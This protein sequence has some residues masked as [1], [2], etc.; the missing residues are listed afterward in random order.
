MPEDVAQKAE[1]LSD[2]IDAITAKRSA[3]DPEVVA[4]G[5]AFVSL[6]SEGEVQIVRG[7]VRAEDEPQPEPEAID[8]NQS[9]VADEQE[10]DGAEE[11]DVE[12]ADQLGRAA[13]RERVGQYV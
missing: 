5:G 4:R 7:F 10:P 6:T 2:E 8:E 9:V 12:D 1:V 13:C 3:Y 11:A